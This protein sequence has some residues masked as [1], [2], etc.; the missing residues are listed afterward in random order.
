[1][2]VSD[3]AKVAIVTGAAGGVGRAVVEL[4]VARGYRVVAAD[5]APLVSDLSQPGRVSVVKADASAAE[6]ARLAVDTA[7]SG[8]GRLDLLV[9]NAARFLLKSMAESTDEDWDTLMAVNARGPF[10]HC[11]AALPH[12]VEFG[13]CIVNVA[14]AAGWAGAAGEAV[15]GSTKGALI[16]L[17]R[18]LAV[19]YGP[20]GVRVNAV[21]PG[22]IDTDFF[23]PA[24]Q[25][26]DP[27][28]ELADFIALHPLGR[29]TTAAEVAAAIAFLG[30]DEAS[31][32]TGAILPVDGGFVAQ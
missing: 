17:T 32:I 4:L 1:M 21:A 27:E 7:M 6:S 20:S 5:I 2:S 26:G 28:T 22:I 3:E 18:M 13:G 16:Q 11:R 30:S 29:M 14:S 9:N 25:T 23:R 12:L 31:A 24:L 8:F 19:E 10:V 15:Y